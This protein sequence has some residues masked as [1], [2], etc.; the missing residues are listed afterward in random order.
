MKEK[1]NSKK[2]LLI[3]LGFFTVSLAWAVYNAFV[4]I[5]LD[6]LI[7]SSLV[8]GFVMT[9]DN[10]FG[11]VFQPMFGSMSD[12][13]TSK[14]GRRMPYLLI[15][16]PIAVLFFIFIPIH[17]QIGQGL[18][19]FMADVF[20]NANFQ[21]GIFT[22]AVLMVTVIGM[23]FSMSIYRAPVVAMMPDSTPAPLRS[24]ANG[25]INFM[26]GLGTVLAFGIGG[27]LFD[28]DERYP[29]LFAAGMML[30]A[31]VVLAVFFKE[32]KVPYTSG[33]NEEIDEEQLN[34]RLFLKKDGHAPLIKQNTSLG[35]MLF[36]IF[37]WFCGYNGVE[38]FFTLYCVDTLQL[39][40]GEAATMLTFMAGS[41]LLFAIP[42]GYIGTKF[43]R[44]HTILSGICAMVFA[45]A[46]I[47]ITRN[48]AVI[49]I[50]MIVGGIGWALININS[51]PMVVQMAPVG[52]TGRYT[53]FYYTFSFAASI[54]SPILFGGI[55]DLTGHYGLLFLYGLIFCFFALVSMMFVKQGEAKKTG[56]MKG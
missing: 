24:K 50:L 22:I 9:I 14:L 47:L 48:I 45:F 40:A 11:V 23:N 10:I 37:F 26:G 32:P 54:L 12:K 6:R 3:G 41:F 2:I 13:T 55:A 21:D 43:G 56:E 17:N 38:T 25:L 7:T 44:K 8:V 53:G 39:G 31:M 15:G 51:Y 36:A 5:F 16:I 29:F 30:V 49:K 46:V 35:F 42:A 19:N 52:Q 33:E 18:S 4:P 28:I 20:P 34:A 1:L 27:R